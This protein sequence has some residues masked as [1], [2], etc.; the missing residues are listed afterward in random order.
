[1]IRRP[2]RSTLFPYTTLFRSPL[3]PHLALP[4][5][6]L[7]VGAG[8]YPTPSPP[9]GSS[10]LRFWFS[11]LDPRP[12]PPHFPGFFFGAPFSP[13]PPNPSFSSL[14]FRTLLPDHRFTEP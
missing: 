6:V 1:M 3:E 8:P 12:P 9:R 7:E 11:R 2:P 4:N 5:R 10:S 14:R 13:P